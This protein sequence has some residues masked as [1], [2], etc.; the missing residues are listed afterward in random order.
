M[1]F[2]KERSKVNKEQPMQNT[3]WMGEDAAPTKTSFISKGFA[4]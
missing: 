1:D 4:Y 2:A 3:I